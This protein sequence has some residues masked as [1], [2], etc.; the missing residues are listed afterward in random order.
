ME[1]L[2]SELARLA[3]HLILTIDNVGKIT[4]CVGDWE[5]VSGFK[6]E[7][8]KGAKL[9][10]F[11]DQSHVNRLIHGN[12]E[13]KRQDE[14]SRLM[15]YFR[16][17]TKARLLVTWQPIYEQ[18]QIFLLAKP[19]FGQLHY[20]WLVDKGSDLARVG[21]WVVDLID[22]E[23]CW[24]PVTAAI[25]E[26]P[27]GY[28]AD[29]SEAIN[30]YVPEHREAIDNAV[31]K[32]ISEGKP[33]DGE[34]QILTAKGNRCWVRAIGWPVFA[35]GELIRLEGVFRDINESK[36]QEIEILQK[37]KRLESYEYALDQHAIIA[38]T[39]SKG[40]IT[41][42]NKNFCEISGYDSSE[43]IGR[44][45]R[46]INS[47]THDDVFFKQLW[48]DIRYKGSWR[49]EICN[50][51]KGGSLYWVDSAITAV[52]DA[53][54]EIVEYLAIRYDITKRKTYEAKIHD[55]KEKTLAANRSKSEFLATMSHEIRTPMNGVIGLAELL[56]DEV[57][58]PEHREQIK[59]IISCGETLV[60]LIND[61]LDYSK[62]EAGKM[63]LDL[64]AFSPAELISQVS[65]ILRP[66]AEESNTS[67]KDT[68]ANMPGLLRGDKRKIGQI[69]F[70]LI[71]NSI[72]F[73]KDKAVEVSADY[74]EKDSI[75]C[76]RV[77]DQGIGMRPETLDSL[78]KPFAQSADGR[79]A[80][81]T[82]LGLAICKR[83]T[84]LMNGSLDVTSTYGEGT[85][86]ILRLPLPRVQRSNDE[87]YSQ[88]AGTES[89]DDYQRLNIL[90]AEDNDVN[91]RIVE[92]YLTRLG[93]KVTFAE[94]GK[95]ARELLTRQIF[96]M[97]L[98]DIH[99]PHFTG[100]EVALYARQDLKLEIPL[101]ALT[102]GVL[103]DERKACFD[104]GMNGFLK[105]PLR[106]SE[107]NE[108]LLE[109]A[110]QIAA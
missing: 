64:E 8:L 1:K 2:F 5:Q 56:Y 104:A 27:F 95:I 49:G 25:H 51:A 24:C 108:T 46:I 74:H 75:L 29:L 37:N 38:K 79:K 88:T 83:I 89:L 12:L 10:K 90:V 36:L 92:R 33:W 94:D 68:L 26:V 30:F 93:C 100:I 34:Y 61:I 14:K 97:A 52:H 66:K 107:L 18:G 47:K 48:R 11:I 57:E 81:G 19:D 82:G 65:A 101:I 105:K 110:K 69:L 87:K 6:P 96:D 40:V 76:I 84:E 85:S 31:Q 60:S 20:P 7:E 17:R 39:D 15:T 54:G 42:V 109:I 44:T 4:D 53:K 106:M 22:Q 62:V 70:N 3:Q 50:K 103:D 102:A 73:A 98:L 13:E 21:R 45:H 23:I 78:F 63:D 43:L 86:V 77:A 32:G 9:E 80:G 35:G 71:G 55:E 99:M 59:T 16:S 67:Y 58:D 91:R 72:K 41:Y 28:K